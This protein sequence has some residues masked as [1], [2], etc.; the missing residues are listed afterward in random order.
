[1]TIKEKYSCP[2][3]GYALLEGPPYANM[4]ARPSKPHGRPPYSER[5]G[6]PSY[7]VC[8]CC[9]YEYGNDD[10]PGTAEPFSFEVYLA[11]W[12]KDGCEWFE[13]EKKPTN[14]NLE[15]QLKNAG[16]DSEE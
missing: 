8:S 10:E 7:D 3:C 2:C 5:Y 13:E 1:M 11:N 9:G 6:M 15:S 4:N 16:I 12:I 14:W